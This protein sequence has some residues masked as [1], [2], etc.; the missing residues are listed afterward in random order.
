MRLRD[1]VWR[2]SVSKVMLNKADINLERVRVCDFPTGEWK[3]K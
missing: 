1:I 3:R 2:S